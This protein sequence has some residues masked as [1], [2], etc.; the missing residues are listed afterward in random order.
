MP[1]ILGG[2]TATKVRQVGEY[3]LSFQHFNEEEA[4]FIWPK[5]KRIG[6]GAMLIP[7]S[8]AYKYNPD[9]MNGESISD[10]RARM[11]DAIEQCANGMKCMGVDIAP[12]AVRRLYTVIGDHLDDLVSM[13]PMPKSLANQG[14]K[15][16]EVTLMQD[17][18]RIATHDILI[19]RSSSLH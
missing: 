14:A 1:V 5:V 6:G 7:L 13:K 16:G 19:P 2:P 3:V 10:R 18:Q 12:H 15:Q 17:G 9:Q 4:M 8:C 11:A